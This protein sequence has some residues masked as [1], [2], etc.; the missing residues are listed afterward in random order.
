M[1]KIELA[2]YVR[3]LF[4]LI[5]HLYLPVEILWNDFVRICNTCLDLVPTKLSSSSFKQPW[6]ITHIKCLS[7]RKQCAY[8]HARNS[9]T[10]EAQQWSNY[11]NLKREC[12]RDCHTAYNKYVSNM[13]DPNKNV[14]TKKLWSYIKNKRQDNIGGVGPLNFQGE[15]HT[16]PLTKT[17]I[18]ANYFSS[19]FTNEDTSIFRLW[20]AILYLI[21]MLSKSIVKVLLSYYLILTPARLRCLEY[22]CK[23]RC[24]L[25][26]DLFQKMSRKIVRTIRVLCRRFGSRL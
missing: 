17:N 25:T 8:D 12:Q 18:F 1:L 9:K 22:Q 2:H 7:R 21:S 15:T 14:V 16:D 26:A 4:P 24:N 6:I 3:S 10:N 5:P 13:V 11:Y 20:K 23:G 19:V